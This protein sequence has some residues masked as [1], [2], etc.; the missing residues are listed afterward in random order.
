MFR[1]IIEY[2]NIIYDSCTK[3]E[4]IKL[5]AIQLEA[6]N[7]VTGAKRGT[8]HEKLLKELGWQTLETRRYMA[9]AT[10][11]FLIVNKKTPKY[12][13]DIFEEFALHGTQNT[14]GHARGDFAI[15]KCKTVSYQKSFV[16]SGISIWNNLDIDLRNSHSKAAFKCKLRR[17]SNAKPLPFYHA[18]SRANQIAFMQLRMG[19]SSLNDHLFHKGC[20]ESNMCSCSQGTEDAAHYFF[21]CNKYTSIRQ[22]MLQKITMINEDIN[23][24]VAL[25]LYGNMSLSSTENHEVL[26]VV[27]WY[28]QENRG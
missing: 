20:I 25:F 21:K 7:I 13:T 11:M 19:F 10:Q 6:A 26:K 2:G 8:S 1:P 17:T 24:S 15:P 4:G 5:E 23:P 3:A 14:R 22:K 27:N 12:L 18:T 9:K 16:N 28:L